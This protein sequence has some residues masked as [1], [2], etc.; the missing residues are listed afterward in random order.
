MHELKGTGIAPGLASGNAV[1]YRALPKPCV[2]KYPIDKEEVEDEHKRLDAAID[3]S[4]RELDLIRI[5]V[6]KEIGQDQAGIFGFHT[7]LLEDQNLIGRIK[8]R[9]HREL[10]N[11]E[12]AIQEEIDQVGKRFSQLDDSYL[13]ER[14]G[15]ISEIGLRILRNLS[16]VG[17]RQV[18]PLN[19]RSIVVT[20]E[21]FPSDTV[22]FNR[23]NVAAIV[24]ERGSENS[25]AAILAR[26]MGIP[27]V[28]AVHKATKE[29][30][31][32]MPLLVDG[33]SG[34]VIVL[35]TPGQN[36]AFGEMRARYAE[37]AL[38]AETEED[39][40]CVTADGIEISLHGN[41]GGLHE[42]PDVLKHNLRGVGLLRSEY[43]FLNVDAP[44]TAEAQEEAYAEIAQ[45]CTGLPITIR[46]MD[47]GGDKYPRFIPEPKGANPDMGMRGLRFSLLHRDLF[48][49]QVKAILRVSAEF[50]VRILL[51]M[52]IDANDFLRAKR[53]ISGLANELGISTVP[54]VGAMI[55]T[56]SAVFQ[57]EAIS[58]E[59]DFLSIGTNDLAQFTL[60]ADRQSMVMA[61]GYFALH[62]AML[63]AVR[64]V[65]DAATSHGREVCVCGEAAGDA[66][67]ACL[68]VGLGIRSLSMS[69]F[70]SSRV[71]FAIRRSNSQRL[72]KIAEEARLSRGAEEVRR[73]LKTL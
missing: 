41:I 14:C 10:V 17:E 70:R 25:H 53:R 24:S 3:K 72:K 2:P 30:S 4:L 36:A 32:G 8:E 60:A 19:S 69:P 39:E 34:S 57:S 9:V 23:K 71:R 42:V 18:K 66:A 65:I 59:A 44:P 5:R 51:P 50:T 49:D 56:P 62:P 67:S 45:A 38:Y 55:E 64:L 73:L 15:D 12:A 33:I 7:A 47:L 13:K 63:R 48:S 26:S 68:L 52:V 46:T 40:P 28:T 61:D 37:E 16:L 6:Q 1:I 11:V 58:A 20:D 22:R 54:A 21:L 31:E 43:L 35:P 29:I 27:F